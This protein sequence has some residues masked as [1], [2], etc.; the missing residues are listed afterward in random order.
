VV[1]ATANSA[2]LLSSSHW[3]GSRPID[4][5]NWLTI[6]IDGWNRTSQMSDATATEVAT[7]DEKIVR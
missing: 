5:R 4:F 3:T 6:P 1:A 7:V 2:V